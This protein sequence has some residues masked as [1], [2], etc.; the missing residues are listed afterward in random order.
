MNLVDSLQFGGL[1]GLF[2]GAIVYGK[3]DALWKNQSQSV[4]FM[5]SQSLDEDKKKIDGH[6]AQIHELT[7]EFKR[8]TS[9]EAIVDEMEQTANIIE[10]RQA[11]RQAMPRPG[12]EPHAKQHRA[13]R[14]RGP[15]AGRGWDRG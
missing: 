8:F 4:E 12:T 1:I 9:P 14:L 7:T 11:G 6:E 10:A 15:G 13:P 2:L 3:R 5:H